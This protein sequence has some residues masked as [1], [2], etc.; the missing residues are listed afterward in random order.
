MYQFRALVFVFLFVCLFVAEAQRNGSAGGEAIPA[1]DRAYYQVITDY[2]LFRPLGWRQPDTSPKYQLIATKIPVQGAPKALIKETRSNKTYYVGVGE[3][4]QEAKVDKIEA[5]QVSLDSGG[6]PIALS[7]R[8]VDFLRTGE[9]KRGRKNRGRDKEK[10]EKR[11]G[12]RNEKS[13]R[14]G[15]GRS[16]RGGWDSGRAQ[17]MRAQWENMSPEKRSEMI[18]KFRNSSSGER[19]KMMG[20]FMR[21]GRR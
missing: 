17:E 10:A 18:Q 16:R 15:R 12:D 20:N 11:S 4:I 8:S 6:K 13:R 5:N 19:R 9:K 21:G 3:E 2:S 7:G 14:G 1:S